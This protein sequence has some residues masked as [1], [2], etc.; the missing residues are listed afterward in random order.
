M[1]YTIN[2]RDAAAQRAIEGRT[3]RLHEKLSAHRR[4]QEAIALGLDH[5]PLLPL[6][7]SPAESKELRAEIR[8]L[9]SCGR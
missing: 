8:T 4:Q 1:H 3:S 7:L 9:A 6:A 2:L 5:G